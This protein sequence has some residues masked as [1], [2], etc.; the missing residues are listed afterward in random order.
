MSGIES[1]IEIEDIITAAGLTAPVMNPQPVYTPGNPAKV[2]PF[3]GG[4]G[5]NPVVPHPAWIALLVFLE[6]LAEPIILDNNGDLT[7][8]EVDYWENRRAAEE[9]AIEAGRQVLLNDDNP[10]NDEDDPTL[11][12]RYGNPDENKYKK[13][14]PRPRDIDGLSFVTTAPV[15]GQSFFV[16]TIEAVNATGVLSALPDRVYS[17]GNMHVPVTP[18]GIPDIYDWISSYPNANISPHEY[19]I[20]LKENLSTWVQ[21]WIKR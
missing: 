19:T 9:K 7:Q 11:I 5:Q 3:P 12:Y 6:I 21:G 14:T 20:M 10:N 2:I 16:T 18:T 8:Q 13:L 15:T 4:N 17:D 1:G